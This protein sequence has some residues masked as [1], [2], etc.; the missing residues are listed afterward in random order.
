MPEDYISNV[1]AIDQ[2]P[3]TIF[4]H[5]LRGRVR[6]STPVAT[7]SGPLFPEGTFGTLPQEQDTF[8][9]PEL[10]SMKFASAARLHAHAA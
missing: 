6:M 2:L 10:W 1:V 5:R 4:V 3:E 7:K 8:A 9:F